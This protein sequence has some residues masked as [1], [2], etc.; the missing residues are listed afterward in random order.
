MCLAC[1]VPTHIPAPERTDQVIAEPAVPVGAVK[2][3]ALRNPSCR[4]Y[5]AGGMLSMMADNLAR[6]TP[7]SP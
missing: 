5:L 3:A 1:G 2:F 7:A 6:L 4:V